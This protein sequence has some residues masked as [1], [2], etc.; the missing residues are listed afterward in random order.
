M[1]EN[2]YSCP[3]LNP[4]LILLKHRL[5]FEE[6]QKNNCDVHCALLLDQVSSDVPSYVSLGYTHQPSLV[7]TDI[8]PLCVSSS[9][10]LAWVLFCVN[11]W[12]VSPLFFPR[13]SSRIYAAHQLIG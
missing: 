13:L 2:V 10:E 4:C 11:I 1:E 7:V 3:G 12:F 9:Q 5:C 6:A 8:K